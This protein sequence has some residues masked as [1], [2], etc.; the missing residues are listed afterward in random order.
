VQS[1]SSAHLLCLLPNRTATWPEGVFA[2]LY[3]CF[4]GV[5]VM[6]QEVEMPQNPAAN[7]STDGVQGLEVC[8]YAGAPF[9]YYDAE[10][11]VTRPPRGPGVQTPIGSWVLRSG[12]SEAPAARDSVGLSR[13]LTGH[14]AQAGG[15]GA[16]R[17]VEGNPWRRRLI[18]Q[19]TAFPPVAGQ[20]PLFIGP[21]AATVV[22]DGFAVLVNGPPVELRTTRG[23][24][25]A[26]A[27][28]ANA[29]LLSWI[30]EGA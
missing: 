1:G 6:L 19:A 16:T 9:D 4:A 28:P 7:N 15:A 8:S 26:N 24:F 20:L 17:L 2:R 14:V 21:N 18:V 30:A 3:G 11:I 29:A 22:T 12:D 23:L 5:R 27:D 13:C 25:V 10:I